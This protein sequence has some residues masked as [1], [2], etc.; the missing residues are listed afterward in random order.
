MHWGG[1]CSATYESMAETLRGG[2]SL[3]LSGFGFWSHDIGGFEGKADAGPL[4]ALGGVRPAFLPQP[5]CTGI[6]SYRVPWLFD[7]EAVDVVR[8][9]TQLKCRLMPYLFA[10]AV[11][12]SRDGVPVMRAMILEFPDD[13]ACRTS[14]GSTCS[15]GALL[16]APVFR[17]DSSV[18]YYVPEGRWTHFL[19]GETIEGGRWRTE[20]HGYLSLPL[21][22]RPGTIV[23]TGAEETR[24]DYDYTVGV[25][26]HLF[27]LADGTS[28]SA[29]V[30][31][32]GGEERCGITARRDGGT[33]TVKGHGSHAGWS[34]LLRGIPAVA[35]VEG[36][37]WTAEPTGTRVSAASQD[38]V[39]RLA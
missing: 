20:N 9:F 32:D 19:S 1:D 39:I 18:T 37:S 22:A 10:A 17:A 38:L 28:T 30:H 13:P 29:A 5:V 14:I 2:L 4:Q 34:L 11:E 15:G 8:F 27:P 3:G 23:A 36:G 6:E 12:A 25:T 24:P 35:A 31:G 26:Y 7:E 21:L 33:I 16:V